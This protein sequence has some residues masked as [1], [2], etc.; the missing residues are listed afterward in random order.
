MKYQKFNKINLPNRTWP[1]NEITKAPIWCSVDLRDGNQALIKPMSLEKKVRFFNLLVAV[2]FKEIEI[3]FPSASEVEYEFTRHLIENNLIPDD[4]TIQILTQAREHLIKKSAE[5]L[6]GAKNV[7][8]HL[9]NPTSTMQR[10]VVYGKSQDEIID[11]AL[12]G[13]KWIKEYF[14]GFE[15]SV[16]FEYSPESFTQTE[17]DY[18]VAISNFV[19][20]AWNP[21]GN[22]KMILNLPSTVE[23]STPN[24]YA[25]QIEY[26]STN[27]V[28]RE[29][30]L[31]SVH[32][33]NDRGCAVAS[34]ELGL[35]AGADR[36][37]GTLLGNGERTGNVD[38]VTVGLNMFT[39]GVNPE[40]D[41]SNVDKIVEVVEQVNEIKTHIR[42]PYVGE[43]VYTAF[44]GSHQ[45]AIKKGMNRQ[46]EDTLWYVPYL[47]I[48][49]KDVGRNYESIIQINS[50]SGKGGVAYILDSVF[51]YKIPKAM[52]PHVGKMIQ[53]V[54]DKFDGVVSEEMIGK[55]FEAYFM[56]KENYYA[57]KNIDISMQNDEAIVQGE[58]FWGE[59][60]QVC[61]QTAEGIIEAISLIFESLGLKFEII[62]YYEHSLSRGKGAEAIAYF[63]I[64]VDGSRYYGVGTGTN[65]SYASIA[66]L[67]SALNVSAKVLDV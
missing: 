38:I 56:N 4:V 26:M 21:Q 55:N 17:L 11:I 5:A 34:T 33:H 61:Q 53:S 3:G 52:E 50:Q 2:G 66:A 25:D 15:G 29:N 35:M 64:E 47:P 22:E 67:V 31:I 16:R 59:E 51:G 1:N 24:V 27:I 37:E 36:V 41:F 30:V 40:L 63:G 19:I 12:D 8:V 7:I 49:P 39:Q 14:S 54:S 45:D 10:D 44:S 42:H 46:E 32:A 57:V 23:S 65:I 18:A 28:R 43:L 13:V 9:Y 48:D 20:E 6:Q 60:R 58:F 62:D